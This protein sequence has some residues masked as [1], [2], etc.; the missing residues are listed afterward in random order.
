MT[1]FQAISSLVFVAVLVAAYLPQ[2]KQFLV[3]LR[4]TVGIPPVP[5]TSAH[6]QMVTDMVTVAELRDRLIKLGCKDGADACT[7]LLR[8]MV[9]FKYPQ[10]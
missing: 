6:K 10:G 7:V 3:K 2:I 5:A 9:E 1:L 8:V 4:P